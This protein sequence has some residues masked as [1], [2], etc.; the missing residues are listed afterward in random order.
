MMLLLLDVFKKSNEV[1][2]AP[3]DAAR[4]RADVV[5]RALSSY[6]DRVFTLTTKPCTR[7]RLVDVLN[8]ARVTRTAAVEV[9]ERSAAAWIEADRVCQK[10]HF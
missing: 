6:P 9:T 10:L 4:R 8:L 1:A 5:T 7:Q 3:T 2:L